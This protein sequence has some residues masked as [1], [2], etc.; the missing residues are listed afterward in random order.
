[1]SD[2]KILFACDL[3][4]TLIHSHR[5]RSGGDICVEL[6]NGREQSFITP[7]ARDLIEKIKAAD[8]IMFVPVTT[9]SIEQYRRIQWQEGCEPE[10]S[11]V[12]NGSVFLKNG[13]IDDEWQKKSIELTRPYEEELNRLYEKYG[14][15][16]CF[17]TVR[18]VDGMFLFAHCR[19]DED[20]AKIAADRAEDT[21]LRTQFSGRKLY[22]FP[23]AADKGRAVRRLF[24]KLEFDEIVAAGDSVIDLPMLEEADLALVP[25][26]DM[27][28]R[29]KNGR[30]F[31][32]EDGVSFSEYILRFVLNRSV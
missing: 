20:T 15:Y 2:K 25:S 28:E 29:L 32:C 22:F 5:C 23:P 11:L 18:I 4:N 6:L 7:H 17:K 14:S 1:M 16:S 8:N 30:V 21:V 9:R 13:I 26:D 19:E 10:L 12:C 27:A 24:Q 31:I 3:D